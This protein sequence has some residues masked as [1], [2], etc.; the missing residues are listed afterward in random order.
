MGSLAHR[1]HFIAQ[2]RAVSDG[3]NDF[4]FNFRL[5]SVYYSGPFLWRAS[6][7]ATSFP[8]FSPTLS[9]SVGRVGEDP[10]N[11]VATA[12]VELLT[13]V[14]IGYTTWV[15]QRLCSRLSHCRNGPFQKCYQN[16]PYSFFQCTRFAELV[17]RGLTPSR[18]RNIFPQAI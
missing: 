8:G 15:T 1:S 4:V 7:A 9:R 10:G 16:Q 13:L 5:I 2:V 18:C 14:S 12:D 6:T 3:G 11:E 17:K